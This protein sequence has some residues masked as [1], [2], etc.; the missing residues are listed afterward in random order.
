[1]QQHQKY[2][3]LFD[4]NGLTNFFLLVA[5]LPDIKGYIKS[6]NQKV[7]SKIIGR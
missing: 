2:F 1:M 4:N 5:N 6:G 3:P 7:R